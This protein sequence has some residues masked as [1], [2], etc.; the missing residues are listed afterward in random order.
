MIDRAKA[1]A[2][3]EDDRGGRAPDSGTTGPPSMAED[4]VA[5]ILLGDVVICPAVAARQAP[6]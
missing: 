3:D 2:G 5:Q 6:E 4:P 1:R